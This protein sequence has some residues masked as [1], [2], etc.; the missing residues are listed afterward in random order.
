MSTSD[1]GTFYPGTSTPVTHSFEERQ[2]IAEFDDALLDQ[3]SW[4]NSRYAGSKLSAKAKNTYKSTDS[5][6]NTTDTSSGEYLGQYVT[7][8]TGDSVWGGDVT[9]Q[10]LPVL[11]YT[12][13]AMYIAN[14]VIGGE[15]DPQFATIR[16]HSYV[17]INRIL[18]I[19]QDTETVQFLD[20]ASENYEEFHRFITNDQRCTG[21]FYGV[22][23]NLRLLGTALCEGLDKG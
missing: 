8:D 6:I 18:L 13:T 19:N 1:G 3:A 7:V 23:V 17:G 11:P 10:N 5:K 21:L 2:M 15:E 9:Y 20:R 22:Q 14:T 16:N 12:S 4:K